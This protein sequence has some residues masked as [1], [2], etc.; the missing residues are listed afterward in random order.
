MNLAWFLWGR[1]PRVTGQ[2]RSILRGIVCASGRHATGWLL[3]SLR[4][5]TEFAI[6]LQLRRDALTRWCVSLYCVR[7]VCMGYIFTH[8]ARGFF[9][10]PWWAIDEESLSFISDANMTARAHGSINIEHI[11]FVMSIYICGMLTI[12]S[13]TCSTS[14]TCTC[15]TSTIFSTI[16]SITIDNMYIYIYIYICFV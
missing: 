15:G 6:L 14:I 12:L 9:R 10:F 1:W 8:N 11:A 5:C 2:P 13:T 3:P 4:S 16:F 7:A